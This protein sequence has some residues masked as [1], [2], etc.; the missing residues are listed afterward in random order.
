VENDVIHTLKGE[1]PHLNENSVVDAIKMNLRGG[2]KE[3]YEPYGQINRVFLTKV[4]TDYESHVKLANKRA[5]QIRDQNK[6]VELTDEQKQQLFEK[7]VLESFDLYRRSLDE[8]LITFNMYD[9][10]DK[11][12]ILKIEASRKKEYMTMAK[13][14]LQDIIDKPNNR[15]VIT[16]LDPNNTD[17]NLQIINIA[18]CM[19]VKDYFNELV[20]DDKLLEF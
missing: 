14:K 13:Y 9:L 6:V 20:K 19:I 7:S 11:K 5:M 3:R 1:F 18:K 8:T 2:L 12:G 17:T 15:I 10:L 4:L 16:Q